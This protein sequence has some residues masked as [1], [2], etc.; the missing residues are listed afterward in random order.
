MT[1]IYGIA[2]VR[3]EADVIRLT[4]IH[5]LSLGFDGLLIVDNGSSDG[6][7]QELARF[8]HDKRVRWTRDDS[9]YHQSEITSELARE[10]FSLGA[11]WVV[12]FDADEFWY[13]RNYNFRQLLS[14]TQA[15]AL[16]VSEIDFIQRREQLFPSPEA[17]LTMTRRAFEPI[18]SPALNQERVESNQFAFVEMKR[19]PKWL[20]RATPEVSFSFGNHEVSGVDGPYERCESLVILHA[21][22]RSRATLEKKTEHGLR[23]DEA[24]EP[25]GI[26]WHARRWARLREEGELEKEWAANSYADGHLDVY[27][28]RRPVVWD[29]TLRDLVAP[30]ISTLDRTRLKL[31]DKYQGAIKSDHLTVQ[32]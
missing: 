26:G 10:A 16:E 17:L 20:C 2:M 24:G 9:P 1:T 6:T 4:I 8:R 21:P 28:S 15:G 18:G 5:H 19:P 25:P 12:P 32:G 30:I 14:E 29:P 22:L 27:G 13:A 23:H 31:Q 11:D 3:N 7:D